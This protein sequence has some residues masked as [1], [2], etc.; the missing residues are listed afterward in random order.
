MTDLP[1]RRAALD[2]LVLAAHAAR[3]M[4]DEAAE[5]HKPAYGAAVRLDF[6]L[7]ALTRAGV[8]I[9]KYGGVTWPDAE[10]VGS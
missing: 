6:A 3:D 10:E 5:H 9:D 2:E 8:S 4:L 1:I 7:L